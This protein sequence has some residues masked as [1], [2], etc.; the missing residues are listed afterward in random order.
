VE[1]QLLIAPQVALPSLAVELELKPTQ[2]I[3]GQGT[4]A[5]DQLTV[6]NVGNAFDTYSLNVAGLPTGIAATLGQTTIDVPPG[7]S[8]F[9]DVSLV[10][11][12]EQGTPPGN[13]PFTV[14]ATSTTDPSV[15]STTDGTLTV[16]AG[17]VKVLLNPPS[18]AP[19]S[20]FAETV[21][22]TG[23]TAD[24]YTLA[25]AGPAALVASL[26]ASQV[27]LAAGASQVVPIS[28]GA[29]NFAVSGSLPLTAA[30][31]STTNPAIQG[32]ASANLNIPSTQ[33]MTASFNPAAQ[34]LSQPG[35]ATFLLMVHNTGNATDSYSATIIGASGPI[36]AS[37]VGPGGSPTQS[38][39]TF[40]LPGLSTGTFEL[41]TSLASE[42][43]GTVTVDV[44]SLTTAAINASP[45]AAVVLPPP[46]TKS[47][48]F[49]GPQVT[50]IERYG[51]HMMPTTLVLTFDQAL[52]STTAE[53]THNYQIVGPHGRTIRVK[54]AVYD[55]TTNSVTLDPGRRINIHYRY[56]LTVDGTKSGGLTNTTGELLDGT[57]SGKP[58]SDYRAALT[59]R[60]LV[61]D[62]PWP[63][64]SR[65]SKTT[66]TNAEHRPRSDS[67]HTVSHK[68]GL[69]TRSL[70]FRR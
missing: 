37:L 24:T 63:K 43:Q 2:A 9:R 4:S 62:P 22:N 39:P 53:D 17:G 14:T 31:T 54:S 15:A 64:T 18:G 29:V 7:I 70:A 42:G 68:A 46:I 28:T 19:G 52:D 25:L 49:D 21:T 50:A 3:A 56:E 11:A 16:V 45:T 60:N 5:L 20:S 47:V 40:I 8:N 69:F 55:P 59:W 6:I 23:T 44:Q 26:G 33:G 1:G 35:T 67:A 27:T 57:D 61:L 58:G 38:I 13:Y 34:I 10:L 51:Y 66:T 32:A 30:A 48:P 12:P 65:R 36:T 41:Q